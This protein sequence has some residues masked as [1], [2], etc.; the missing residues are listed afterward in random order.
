M[1]YTGTDSTQRTSA[2]STTFATS[3]FGVANSKTGTTTTYFTHD[4]TGR[5][6]SV[7]VGSNRYY[8]YY[9]GAGSVAGMFD[10]SG[11]NVASYSY[12]PY[13][14]TTSSGTQASANPFRFRGGYQD[15]TGFYKFGKRFLNSST[16][17]WT[18]QDPIAGPVHNA[19][20]VN[21]YQYAG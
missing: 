17:S 21:R 15:T 5:L 18:Q 12:D 1:A 14:T 8:V 7:I 20:A 4:S 11:S 3:I 9:D 10:S 6:N 13:G 16:G 19:G 2:G